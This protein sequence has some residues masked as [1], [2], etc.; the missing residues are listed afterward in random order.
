MRPAAE[1]WYGIGPEHVIASRPAAEIREAAAGASGPEDEPRRRLEVVTLPQLQILNDEGRKP[2][3]IAEHVGRRPIFA[4]G[5]VGTTG[6]IEMLRWSQSGPRRSL[7][8]LVLHDDADREMAYGEP[9]N[10]SLE[11]AELYGWTVVRMAQDWRRIFTRT[12]EKRPPTETAAPAT[13][14]VGQA[15]AAAANEHPAPPRAAAV[16]TSRW[17]Q[18]VAAIER[19]DRENPPV[20]GGV[21]FLGSSNVRMWTTLAEDFAG[22]GP[23]NRGVGG[24]RLAELP[25]LAARLVAPAQPAAVVVSAGTNDVSAGATPEEIRTAFAELVTRL[26][27]AVPGVRIAFLAIAP[28]ISRWGQL[29]RQQAANAAVRAFITEQGADAGLAYF[30]ANA[31]LLNEQ[32]EPAVECFLDDRQHPSTIGNARRAAILRPLLEDFVR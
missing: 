3:S 27:E 7:Q 31:A 19:A 29:E 24:A 5:N 2:I 16:G 32:G 17:E 18:E 15:G 25:A 28:S 20:P 11:A 4:A 12:L 6:D 13:T 8:V 21:V 23:S 1:A 30:D 10:D 9:S 14:A 22:L 26:R